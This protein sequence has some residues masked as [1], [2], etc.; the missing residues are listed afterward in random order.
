M[1]SLEQPEQQPTP[2][3]N[4][5]P[6]DTE[7]VIAEDTLSVH[8][9]PRYKNFMILGAVV[10]VVSALVLTVA[11]PDSADF[12]KAQ[13]FGFLLLACLAAGVLLGSIVA[14]VLDRAI[15]RRS[16]RVVAD[17]LTRDDSRATPAV[18]ESTDTQHFT[19]KSE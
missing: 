13:I 9:S 8:R 14:L 17:R 12:N 2:P 3:P 15:G 5:R 19:E 11:F 6:A 10:G 16:H 4:D 1:S 18:D 7:S